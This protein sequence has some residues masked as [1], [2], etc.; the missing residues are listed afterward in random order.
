MCRDQV[1]DHLVKAFADVSN[2][3]HIPIPIWII[4]GVSNWSLMYSTCC[5]LGRVGIPYFEYLLAKCDRSR[6]QS[7]LNG[8]TRGSQPSMPPS[9][10]SELVFGAMP[11]NSSGLL[12]ARLASKATR[13]FPPAEYSRVYR[14]SLMKEQHRTQL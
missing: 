11:T 14:I 13:K 8:Q 5:F 6:R 9:H 1:P 3:D 10:D 4:R 7:V 12:L 2:C